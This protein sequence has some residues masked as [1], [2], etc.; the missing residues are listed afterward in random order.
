MKREAEVNRNR[1]PTIDEKSYQ[2]FVWGRYI[3]PEQIKLSEQQQ[4]VYNMR[5]AGFPEWAI[6]NRMQISESRVR[7]LI[8][9]IGKKNWW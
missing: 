6:A 3:P 2:I 1:L 9:E 5:I 8:I 4:K 7:N